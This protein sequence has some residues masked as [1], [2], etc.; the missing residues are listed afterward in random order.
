MAN[1]TKLKNQRNDLH[2]QHRPIPEK[3]NKS[4]NQT[5]EIYNYYT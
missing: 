3:N 5:A 4:Y 2:L 1:W